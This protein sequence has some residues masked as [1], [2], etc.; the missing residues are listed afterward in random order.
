MKID[1]LHLLWA[2]KGVL[3]LLISVYIVSGIASRYFK[4][5]KHL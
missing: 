1:F 3:G 5:R 4:A 2:M